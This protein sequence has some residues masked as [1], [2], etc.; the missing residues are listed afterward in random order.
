MLLKYTISNMDLGLKNKIIIVT[1]GSKGIGEC[2]ALRTNE[3]AIQNGF[4][5]IAA[6]ATGP[7]SQ[8]IAEK[9]GLHE[10]ARVNYCDFE[11]QG[12]KVFKGIT[13]A[14]GCVM[15]LKDLH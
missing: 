2:M 15:V 3:I 8:H 9:Y 14:T 13:E 5:R 10:I 12:K 6:E 1:G 11:Y 4:K 7:I